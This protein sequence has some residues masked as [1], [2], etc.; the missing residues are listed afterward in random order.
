MNGGIKLNI[1]GGKLSDVIHL[2][3]TDIFYVKNIIGVDPEFLFNGI[4]ILKIVRYK[5]L[6]VFVV[7]V[8]HFW[9]AWL[10]IV[11]ASF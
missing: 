11:V 10:F 6:A 1:R 4:L 8:E 5:G 3:R 7:I 2:P 9:L